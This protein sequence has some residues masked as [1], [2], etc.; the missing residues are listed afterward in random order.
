MPM[1]TFKCRNCSLEL[2]EMR[3]MGDFKEPLCPKCQYDPEA[4]G[5]YEKMEKIFKP[6]AKP[7]SKDGSWDFGGKS[8]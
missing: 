7:G 6:N 8:K 4:Q 3:Q 2:E 5:K 1:Y